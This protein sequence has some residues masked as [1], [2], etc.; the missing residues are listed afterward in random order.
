M[1]SKV[2]AAIIVLAL[3][4]FGLAVYFSRPVNPSPDGNASVDSAAAPAATNPSPA[5][6]IY[7][8]APSP[9]ASTPP[10]VATPSS[11]PATNHAAYVQERN[12]ELMSLAMNNDS[13][14][15]NTIWSELSNADPEIRAGALAAVVQ[16][17]DRSVTPRLR[18]LAAQTP[19]TAEKAEIIKAADFLDL[20]SLTE[21]H[22]P[23]AT[24][25]P[26]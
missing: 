25:A 4:A 14:S 10:V 11:M 20:P 26:Q 5:K 2:V 24:N 15:L 7:I 1:N 22:R 6:V 16:F 8:S 21:L 9:V 17:G 13:N 23:P 19:D 3:G 18:E 12:A